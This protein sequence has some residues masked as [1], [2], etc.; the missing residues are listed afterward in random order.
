M[1]NI[2]YFA[3]ISQDNIVEEVIVADDN[4]ISMKDGRWIET[5]LDGSIRGNY[6][7]I[8]F[9]YNEDIDA[10]ISQKPFDTWV[11]NENKKWVPPIEKPN[12][13]FEYFWNEDEQSWIKIE[14]T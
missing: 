11:L 9:T 8:G 5:K 6:A 1:Q 2:R 14:V 4:F 10:F 7:G 12:D 13:E 3:K